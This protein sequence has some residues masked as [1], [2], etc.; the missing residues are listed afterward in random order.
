[1]E[2]LQ[3]IMHDVA[4]AEVRLQ[5]AKQQCWADIEAA[6][7]WADICRAIEVF[8]GVLAEYRPAE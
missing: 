4:S 3:G 1:M 2:Q 6:G 5:Q 7:S 8:E